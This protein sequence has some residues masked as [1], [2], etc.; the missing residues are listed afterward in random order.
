M[1]GLKKIFNAAQETFAGVFANLS[2]Y[3]G[4]LAVVPAGAAAAL[5]LAT[6]GAL[7]FAEKG[8]DVP[9]DSLAMIH[10][11]E[12]VLPAHLADKVRNMTGAGGKNSAGDLHVHIHAMDSQ[13]VERALKNNQSALFKILKGGHRNFAFS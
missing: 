2:P 7:N 13:D 3:L 12:M 11:N 6:G 4:P 9:A 8:W 5:V 1:T 10:K